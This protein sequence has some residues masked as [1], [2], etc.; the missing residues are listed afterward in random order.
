MPS[1]YLTTPVRAGSITPG[2][3]IGLNTF[4]ALGGTLAGGVEDS[5]VNA[6][7]QAA[8][9][10]VQL[11]DK[12]FGWQNQVIR[13]WV[14]PSTWSPEITLSPDIR[15]Q[16]QRVHHTGLYFWQNLANGQFGLMGIYT[17][18][19]DDGL[20]CARYTYNTD[21]WTN[22]NFGNFQ[23]GRGPR[24]GAAVYQNKLYWIQ[25]GN[26]SD[27][28][29]SYDPISN[30]TA[31]ASVAGHFGLGVGQVGSRQQFLVAENGL[32]L[33]YGW[34]VGG[35]G[36]R[37]G[38][39]FK[40]FGGAWVQVA[41]VP[42][43]NLNVSGIPAIQ[44]HDACYYHG[45]SIWVTLM[46]DQ[47]SDIHRLYEID[48]ATFSVTDRTAAVFPSVLSGTAIGNRNRWT[49]IPVVDQEDVLGTARTLILWSAGS[50]AET[51]NIFEHT[52]NSA[53]WTDLGPSGLTNAMSLPR[54][55][56]G[57]S[58]GIYTDG[59][60][61]A[62]ITQ[63]SPE[64]AGVELS[65]RVWNTP[66]NPTASAADKK[67]RIRYNTG[68][69]AADTI[70]QLSVPT[71]GLVGG[72]TLNGNDLEGVTNDDGVTTYKVKH[73]TVAQGIPSGSPLAYMLELER[74]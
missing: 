70:A 14:P 11:A 57:G 33:Y 34:D 21:S 32:Y 25:G 12:V 31:N 50:Q 38:K 28:V 23:G 62:L 26:N 47:A 7:T 67:L 41:S 66:Q 60:L 18:N 6:G 46:D 59:E 16:E 1:P 56:N 2:R 30:S 37:T 4:S 42:L 54:Y 73:N 69:N 5:G 44:S 35:G 74:P 17:T 10:V 36:T 55:P 22:T 40:L 13:E 68:E 19:P 20:A 49:F 43:G 48:L 65:I 27:T 52:S 61:W 15:L 72:T 53:K 29:W 24:L 58:T 9:R 8:N 51:F 64:P 63:V 39:L 71:G 3:L 45:G